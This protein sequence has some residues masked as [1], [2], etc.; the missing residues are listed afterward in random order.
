MF[1]AGYLIV[2]GAF[3]LAATAAQWELQQSALLSPM[4]ALASPLLGGAVFILAGIY[5]FTPLK[6]VCLRHCRSPFAF[7]LNHWRDG[8]RGALVSPSVAVCTPAC[9]L[10]PPSGRSL[11]SSSSAARIRA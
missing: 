9:M 8:R 7:V 11:R 6:N 3:C 1:A 4:L 10:V 2:W 5:Q